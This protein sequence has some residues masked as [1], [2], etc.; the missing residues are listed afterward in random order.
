MLS[1]KWRLLSFTFSSK[2]MYLWHYC[3]IGRLKWNFSCSFSYNQ[4]IEKEF[5]FKGTV[6]LS[7][8]WFRNECSQIIFGR[9][10]LISEHPHHM[11]CVMKHDNGNYKYNFNLYVLVFR[12]PFLAKNSWGKVGLPLNAIKGRSLMTAM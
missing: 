8:L 9:L 11:S 6:Q 3:M 12:S 5:H 7:P 2:S 10:T 4:L 1:V